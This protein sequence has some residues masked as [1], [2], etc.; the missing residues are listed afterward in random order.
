MT[1]Y[2]R[3]TVLYSHGCSFYCYK[4]FQTLFKS[5]GTN[6]LSPCIS[7][8]MMGCEKHGSTLSPSVLCLAGFIPK[9]CLKSSGNCITLAPFPF[10]IF[11][12]E[13]FLIYP[14]RIFLLLFLSNES[15]LSRYFEHKAK[16]FRIHFKKL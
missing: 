9:K 14:L 4:R 15:I 7:L 13:Q 8:C 11:Y 5:N 16:N 2:K 12:K 6:T 1:K 3:A 10:F